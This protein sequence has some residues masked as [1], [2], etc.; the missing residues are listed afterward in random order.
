MQDQIS[1]PPPLTIRDDLGDALRPLPGAIF[2]VVDGA[3]FDDLPARMRAVGLEALPLYA[4][5]IDLPNM[6]QGPHLVACP[7]GYAI[8]QVRDVCSGAP[9]V[10]WWAWPDEG[11]GTAHA[12]QS[13]LRRLNLVEIPA[14]RAEAIVGTRPIGAVDRSAKFE[15]VIFRHGD[16]HVMDLLLPV[17]KPKQLAQLFGRAHAMVLDAPGMEAVTRADNPGDSDPT[18]FGRLRL[19]KKQYDE[20]AGVHGRGLRRRA[21]RELAHKFTDTPAAGREARVTA[22][23]DRAESYGCLTRSQIWEF[24]ALDQ[25]FGAGFEFHKGHER[26]LEALQTRDASPEE[27]L[28]RAEMEL[29]FVRDHGHSHD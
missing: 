29:G 12:I 11:E 20:L 18:A 24:L 13:H 19:S 15:T 7:N 14:M 27:R 28:W 25:K 2:A 3:H 21:V 6:S 17:L 23:Y 22:A 10:V 1:A 9:A 4:D 26:V 8:E 5:E 16:P